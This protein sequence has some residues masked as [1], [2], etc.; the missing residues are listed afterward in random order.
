LL[1]NSRHHVR[2]SGA[3]NGVERNQRDEILTRPL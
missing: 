1:D 3:E 2:L